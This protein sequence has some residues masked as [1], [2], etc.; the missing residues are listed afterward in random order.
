MDN[1]LLGLSSD[2]LVLLLAAL[3][4]GVFL[5]IGGLSVNQPFLWHIGVRNLT[6]RPG[7]TL[8]LLCGLALSLAFIVASFSLNDSF[9]A[10]VTAQRLGWV[11]NVDESVS[12]HFSQQ[13]VTS[14]LDR[15]RH[16]PEVQAAS[17][18]YMH[19]WDAEIT[20]ERT[21]LTTINLDLYGLPPDFEQVYGTL[22]DAQGH[23]IHLADMRPNEVLLSRSMLQDADVR[24]GD[25]IQINTEF[26][27]FTRTVHALLS[28][29]LVV[30]TGELLGGGFNPEI[31]MPLSSLQQ[32]FEH[33]T[34]Q[35]LVPNVL[36]VKNNGQGGMADIGPGG[37]RSRDVLSA[38]QHIFGVA[39]IDVHRS[40]PGTTSFD[41]I[42]IHPLKPDAVQHLENAPFSNG[43]ALDNSS[44]GRQYAA[45]LP[46]FT[47]FLV[48]TGMLLLVLLFILLA[49]ERR[50]ELG[51]SRAI[52][53]QRH[54]LV[55]SLLV[56][57]CGYS[58]VAASLGLPLGVGMAALELSFLAHLPAVLLAS[59][60]GAS[61]ATPL[62]F[63]VSWQSIISAGSLGV[64]TSIV[65]VLVSALWIARMSIVA[66]I[67]D[68][69]EPAHHQLTLLKLIC[70][71]R[72][73]PRDEEGV[74]LA[75]TSLRRVSRRTGALLNLLWGFFRRGPLCLLIGS[76]LFGAASSF[77]QPWLEE[78]GICVLIVAAGLLLNWLLEGLVDLLNISWLTPAFPRRLC[79]SLIGL[80]WLVYGFQAGH[81]LFLTVLSP[82]PPSSEATG[83]LLG[84]LLSMLSLVG[85]AVMLM[86]TNIDLLATCLSLLMRQTRTL[87]PISR[88]SLVYP[89]TYRFRTAVTVT[90]LSL[91]AFLVMLLVTNNLGGVQAAQVSVTTGNFQL[92]MGVDPGD[93][94]QLAPLIHTT[95][96]S[97][98][99][100]IAAIAQMH[101]LYSAQDLNAANP[102]P[103][104]L[105]L[106]GQPP[107]QFGG[108][109]TAT[110]TMVVDNTFLSETSM[111][112]FARA[113]GYDSDRQIWNA[114]RD[115]PD[116][117]VMQ[118]TAH[119]RG[120]PTG[121]GFTPFIAEVP[122]STAS[123]PLYHQIMIIGLAPA[124][125]HWQ[126]ILLSTR[127][128]AGMV[129]HASTFLTTYYFR[130]QPGV[131][132]TRASSDLS[133]LLQ[134]GKY[135]IQIV[136]LV[137]SDANAF[138]TNLTLFLAGYLT[139]GLLFGAL[140]IGVIT[141]RAVVERR[142]QI[143]MLRA[144]GFSHTLI[145]RSFLLESSFVILASLL[146]GSALAWWL[147]A[148]V[149]GQVYQ[150][151][152]VP[153]G[154]MAMLFLG[155]YLVAFICT[156]VPAHRAS[157]LP[158]A[159]ALRYE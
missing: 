136:S 151:F 110:A 87:A 125:T 17:A 4:G 26:G 52:G 39:P 127:T 61:L 43:R 13:Q 85:G 30:T 20:S 79:L 44:A 2:M 117:A 25:T 144:L 103:V 6:R 116:V 23:L 24:P 90:L 115:H 64:L 5:I 119:V 63:W 155:S 9:V 118:Y 7:Q 96:T 92:E 54:H 53:M 60:P 143:G 105:R 12:G 133:H 34:H 77:H 149:A 131:S 38:L 67:R 91:I 11:G 122:E 73:H 19:R 132:A 88:T 135:G 101:T 46:A 98:H 153:L 66:A 50:S 70:A 134:T 14:A 157:R 37:N 140:S 48:G 3:T 142:Q 76:V 108:S 71:F 83:D 80:G 69:P 93:N 113:R 18:I 65:V 8:L 36:C 154:P 45:L 99:Q 84:T 124:N 62:H 82:V 41:A 147:A 78:L 58:I 123:S 56:E 68:L 141:S 33:Q 57:G 32:V 129:P 106:P 31:I 137:A 15:I 40:V 1:S 150:S 29:D 112:L 72:M 138:T 89:F 47:A 114:V 81:D 130:L 148:W 22:T 86:M 35:P 97:L 42:L 107:Q 152:P 27:S 21:A 156:I 109:I 121:N 145:L 159:E 94:Q 10:S 51:M 49:T 126:S 75:E 139:L 16:Q 128:A 158:P 120:L 100:D 111:P 55:Q 102:Q 146:L 59:A 74:V 28:N 104:L 95:A